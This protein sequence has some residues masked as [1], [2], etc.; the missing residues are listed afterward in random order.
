MNS[1]RS[2]KRGLGSVKKVGETSNSE[3]SAEKTILGKYSLG[4]WLVTKK[5][6]GLEFTALIISGIGKIPVI[7]ALEFVFSHLSLE[8]FG[9]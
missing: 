5:G 9:V 2:L 4:V 1:F 7:P 8:C 3:F 6:K